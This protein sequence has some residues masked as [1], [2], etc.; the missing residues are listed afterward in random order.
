MLTVSNALLIFR[1]TAI[2]RSIFI[3]ACCAGV[4]YVV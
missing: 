3:K 1:A 2:V 4:V